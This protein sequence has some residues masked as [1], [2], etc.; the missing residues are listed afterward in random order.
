MKKTIGFVGVGTMGKPMVFNLMKAGY[1]L[2][3]YDIN[4]KPLEE[5]KQGGASVA[6]SGAEAASK[7]DVV[8][9]M[10]PKSEH[11]EAA[12]LG[13]NGVIKGVKPGT[14]VI[15]M[16]TI[17]PSVAKRIAGILDSQGVKMLDA[18][19]TGGETGA[20]AATLTIMVGGD[21]DAYK[22]C[23]DIFNAM[24]KNIFYCGPSGNG[25]IVK[26]INNLFGG[27]HA[28]ST[29]EALALGVKAGVDFKV[30]Y[31]VISVGTG[32]TNFMKNYCPIKAFKG[33]FEPGFMA[34]LMHK[35]LG[36]AVTLAKEKDVPLL[37]G[38]LTY[39]MF[40]RIMA[41]GL[42]KKDFSITVKTFEDLLNIKMKL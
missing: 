31:D 30:L 4:P 7:A 9:T 23:L 41:E 28:M 39:Q 37:M 14:I 36:L 20:Q 13:E 21:E 1:Q 10:L 24:G 32:V 15:D 12:V 25:D 38:A 3:V 42:G 22:Q 8:I 19:V 26:V 5:L 34:E 16:S 33:D 40:T 2:V 27:I 18:P 17:D 35:D 6:K 11:V 29:A